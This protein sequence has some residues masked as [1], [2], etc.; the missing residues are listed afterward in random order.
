MIRQVCFFRPKKMRLM[1]TESVL[2]TE[3]QSGP[4]KNRFSVALMPTISRHTRLHFRIYQQPEKLT[5]NQQEL[6]SFPMDEIWL[7]RLIL[8][9]RDHD[10]TC[11]CHMQTIKT[12]SDQCLGYSLHR[13]YINNSYRFYYQNFKT[14]TSFWSWAGKLE[15]YLVTH[16]RRQVFSWHGSHDYHLP[17]QADHRPINVIPDQIHPGV[18]NSCVSGNTMGPGLKHSE[19]FKMNF[20]NLINVLNLWVEDRY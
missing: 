17:G 10:K 20:S 11:L 13:Q 4:A 2:Q 18:I 14:M 7:K 6:I 1:Q 8:P 16:L 19:T 12:Q 9:E 5:P 15:S 3:N